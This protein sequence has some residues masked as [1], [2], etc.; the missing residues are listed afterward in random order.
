MSITLQAAVT[1]MSNSGVVVSST[2]VLSYTGTWTQNGMSPSP[3]RPQTSA[4]PPSPSGSMTTTLV[5]WMTSW[6]GPLSTSHLTRMESKTPSL[7]LST[8][9]SFHCL[10]WLWGD[11][12]LMWFS[13]TVQVVHINILVTF[14]PDISFLP[15]SIHPSLPLPFLSFLSFL[16]LSL[17]LSLPPHRLHIVD[18]GLEDPVATMR[19]ETLGS[20]RIFLQITEGV[21]VKTMMDSPTAKVQEAANLSLRALACKL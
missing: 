18:L 12:E 14:L 19:G 2:G 20:I 17:P 16:P 6:G 7:P 15:P 10:S 1:H 9:V 3:L 4:T 11:C 8:F 13:F 21:L 5:P